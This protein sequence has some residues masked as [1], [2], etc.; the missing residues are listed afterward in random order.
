MD[1]ITTIETRRSVKKF[2]PEHIMTE[3]E[4]NK[5]MSLAMLSPT[6]FNIQ[7]WRFVLVCDKELRKDIRAAAWDQAQVTEASLLIAICGDTCAWAKD[8]VRYWRN[9]PSAVQ[10]FIVPA[11]SQYYGDDPAAA[12]DEV[13]RSCGI[14]AQTIMLAARAMGY[15][16]CPMIGF[17]FAKVGSLINLPE[18]HLTTMFVT[19][20]KS[21]EAARPRGGQLAME[22]VV[23]KDRF[24]ES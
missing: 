5:L 21:L 6:A 19:V 8:T 20:G 9:A 7:H 18:D 2:D 3:E 24:P 4:I 13:I 14:A 1:A 22:E 11:I 12:H 23:F 10:D 16:S 15:D 17:D